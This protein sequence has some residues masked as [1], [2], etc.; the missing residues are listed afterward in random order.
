MQRTIL[1][2]LL[3]FSLNG[4]LA[5]NSCLVNLWSN[6]NFEKPSNSCLKVN[7]LNNISNPAPFTGN[8]VFRWRANKPFQPLYLDEVK[9]DK[10][11]GTQYGHYLYVDPRNKNAWDYEFYQSIQV[12][13]NTTYTFS[14][15]Y[16]SMN[17]PTL[18]PAQI[19][20]KINND[21]LTTLTI[22]NT[23]FVW[24]EIKVTWNSG[25]STTAIARFE[26]FSSTIMG[27][28]FA[29]DD[30]YFGEGKLLADAGRDTVLCEG[31]QVKLGGGIP[32]N[33]GVI[34]NSGYVY[35]W[36]P[37]NFI[38]GSNKTGNPLSL[39][40]NNS[41]AFY[42][43]IIDNDS[44]IC[45]DTVEV[46]IKFKQ[47]KH[48]DVFR[49][50]QVCLPIAHQ[51]SLSSKYQIIKWDDGSKAYSRTLKDTGLYWIN[52]QAQC[53]EY[54]DSIRL[55]AYPALK[56]VKVND[57]IVCTQNGALYNLTTYNP[58]A[59]FTWGD[60]GK[61]K[62]RLFTKPGIYSFSFS[63]QCK[64]IS[65]TFEIKFYNES[66]D[67]LPDKMNIC[68]NASKSILIPYTYRTILWNDGD[69][70]HIK[71]FKTKGIYTV[72]YNICSLKT[73]SIE[74]DY[75][76]T[77]PIYIGQ[78]DSIC[79]FERF[80]IQGPI[81]NNYL[82]N[83][84]EITQSIVVKT[85]GKYTLSI[86]DSNTCEVSDTIELHQKNGDFIFWIPT[87]FTPNDDGMNERFPDNSLKFDAEIKIYSR[88]G[89]LIWQS[90][91]NETWDG[92]LSNGETCSE[93]L[94]MYY[95]K[96]RDCQKIM[97]VKT[98]TFYILK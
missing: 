96:Y 79:Y 72:S 9:T 2:P 88:W 12:E 56:Q 29:I 62:I 8:T 81:A 84:G 51:L 33:L 48:L 50:T 91:T 77:K 97:R 75:F 20:L 34:C 36:Q 4:V 57:T 76:N 94:L 71:W 82:W 45:I 47:K 69:S 54:S 23:P 73:D 98:G 66:F 31:E 6:G 17:K 38:S 27:Y 63:D 70:S 55:S 26:T 39:P 30:I 37:S 25:N 83:T 3:F 52:F 60:T 41:R 92:K 80:L 35:E 78:D 58:V 14:M 65:D 13:K 24:K 11:L 5:Q 28:D 10:T 53:I 59:N 7:P 40:L 42:L 85:P 95:I 44:N 21:I 18:A 67:V 46:E 16:C 64:T 68:N 87:A 32:G 61:F 89:E 86:Q 1:I 49:D 74:I 90:E 93:N 19:R 15:W 43:K 22:S